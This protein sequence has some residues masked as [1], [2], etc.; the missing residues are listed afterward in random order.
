[1][2]T[3]TTLNFKIDETKNEIPNISKLATTSALNAK[4]NVVKSEIPS[5]TSLTAAVNKISNVSNN[6]I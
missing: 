3:N 1:M 6:V 2:A 5:I 4:I